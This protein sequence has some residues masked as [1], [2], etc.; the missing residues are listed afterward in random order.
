MKKIPDNCNKTLIS[1]YKNEEK[2]LVETLAADSRKLALNQPMAE[3][4]KG[5][6]AIPA[7]I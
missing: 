7:F 4:S 6:N 5:R 1:S 3:G 2:E